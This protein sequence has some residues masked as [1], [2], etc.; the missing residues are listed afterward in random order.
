M[1]T[2]GGWRAGSNSVVGSG[3]GGGHVGE[4]AVPTGEEVGSKPLLW[5]SVP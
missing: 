1:R 2:G 5:S 3:T 4:A